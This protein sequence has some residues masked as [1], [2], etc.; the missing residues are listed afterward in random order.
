MV[1]GGTT[2][3]GSRLARGGEVGELGDEFMKMDDDEIK[4]EKNSPYHK[5]SQMLKRK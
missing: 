3:G 1:S 4:G 5:A 2:H